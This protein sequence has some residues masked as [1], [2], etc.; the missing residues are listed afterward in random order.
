MPT[1]YQAA[2]ESSHFAQR[3]G[4][5]FR[6]APST[7]RPGEQGHFVRRPRADDKGNVPRQ[8]FEV[9]P[10]RWGLIPLFSKDGQDPDTFE[11]RSETAAAERNFYQPW[12]RGHRCVILAGAIFQPA[13]GAG[14][15]VRVSRSDGEPLALAGLWNGWRSPAG[16]CVESFALLT[17]GAPGRPE[18]RRAVIL[19]DAWIDDWL[20][21]PVE[22]TAAYLRPYA[23]DKLVRQALPGNE[24]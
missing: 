23:D 10:G 17:F 7:V 12:K 21:C 6:P 22:E 15:Q 1:H 3:F 14:A 4:L 19:R 20:H 8:R 13:E 5:S 18:L 16:D 24:S 11:A 2:S 9:A